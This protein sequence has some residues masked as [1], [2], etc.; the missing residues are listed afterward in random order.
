MTPVLLQGAVLVYAAICNSSSC[1][2]NNNL[3]IGVTFVHYSPPQEKEKEKK[4][5]K[6]VKCIHG[7]VDSLQMQV[8]ITCIPEQYV[9][10]KTELNF[11][12]Q[13]FHQ[14]HHHLLIS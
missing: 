10:N 5:K 9:G 13:K 3:F 1:I 11:G 6:S 8:T 14:N 7:R 12:P 4:K 2:Q